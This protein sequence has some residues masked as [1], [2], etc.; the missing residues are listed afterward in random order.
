MFDTI[1]IK[2]SEKLLGRIDESIFFTARTYILKN[3]NPLITFK[4]MH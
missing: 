2:S 3:K 4:H 1:S